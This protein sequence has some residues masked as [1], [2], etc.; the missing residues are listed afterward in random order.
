M[1]RRSILPVVFVLAVALNGCATY[2]SGY[3]SV[4]A[5]G[6]YRG[7]YDGGY[8]AAASEGSGDYYYDRPEVE[9]NDFYG[10]YGYPY[11]GF[12]Y[13]VGYFP[14]QFGFGFGYS[15][16]FYQP[17]YGYGYPRHHW[18]RRHGESIYGG[19]AAVNMGENHQ[20]WQMQ[21]G[22]R[23][24]NDYD[25]PAR[26]ANRESRERNFDRASPHGPHHQPGGH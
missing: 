6:N 20:R 4:H 5:D 12:G 8:Y 22:A 15:P 26:D 25:R 17:W 24:A 18:H 9:F 14:G 7:N 16:W 3:R 23:P 19:A 1:S 2:D 21:P 10:G 13:G 11:A